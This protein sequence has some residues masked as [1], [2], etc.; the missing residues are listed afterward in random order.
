MSYVLI[1]AG[2][3]IKAGSPIQ[4]KSNVLIEARGF[5]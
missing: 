1:E 4:A 3:Q 2:F 5:Y